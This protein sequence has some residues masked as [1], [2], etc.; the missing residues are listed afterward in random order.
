M[1]ALR[2]R[3]NDRSNPRLREAARLNPNLAPA[4]QNLAWILATHPDPAK[5]DPADAV[6]LAERANDLSGRHSPEMMDTLG[7]SYAAAGQFDQA[8][9]AAASAKQLADDA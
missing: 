7:A 5:R 9:D 6:R 2:S 1:L 3:K 4:L 8:R